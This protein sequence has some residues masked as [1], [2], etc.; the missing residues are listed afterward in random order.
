MVIEK[1]ARVWSALVKK[2]S[3]SVSTTCRAQVAKSVWETVS[4]TKRG[5][6][7]EKQALVLC[8]METSFLEAPFECPKTTQGNDFDRERNVVS[9]CFNGGRRIR[10]TTPVVTQF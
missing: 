5:N 4:Q 8:T 2:H 1:A 6:S 10:D 9:R 7:A 3:G